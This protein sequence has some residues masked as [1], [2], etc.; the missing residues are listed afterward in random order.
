MSLSS[1]TYIMFRAHLTYYLL[2]HWQ[3]LVLLVLWYN[4]FC[5]VGLQSV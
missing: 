1:D 4:A 5:S 2:Y 3:A